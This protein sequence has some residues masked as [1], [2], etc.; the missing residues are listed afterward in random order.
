[1]HAQLTPFTTSTRLP[2]HSSVKEFL[3]L[4]ASTLPR[5][6]SQKE[7]A[8]TRS[9]ISRALVLLGVELKP[10]SSLRK[11]RDSHSPSMYS[12]TM[13]LTAGRR[14]PPWHAAA[15]EDAH[16]GMISVYDGRI[17]SVKRVLHVSYTNHNACGLLHPGRTRNKTVGT[18]RPRSNPGTRQT[19]GRTTSNPHLVLDP[20]GARRPERANS[21]K[22]TGAHAASATSEAKHP[23]LLLPHRRGQKGGH[24]R[25]RRLM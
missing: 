15:Y 9:S 18:T 21:A 8:L 4:S 11:R 7:S 1:M 25:V 6:Q 2:G 12:R 20:Q 24:C 5:S 19:A 10:A 22:K 14:S 17:V 16:L 13:K 3:S 23:S